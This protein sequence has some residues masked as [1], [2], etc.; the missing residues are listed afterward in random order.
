[1]RDRAAAI[2]DAG[3][4]AWTSEVLGRARADRL[5]QLAADPNAPAFFGR[6]DYDDEDF[7]I[8]RRHIRNQAGDPVVIDWRAPMSTSFYRATTDDPQG[9]RRR[10]R[11]GFAG[12]RLTSYED[13]DL[14]AGVVDPLQSQILLQEIERPRVGPMRDIV[15][16]IQPDQDEIVRADLYQD[17]CVQGAPGTGKTAVGLHRAAYLIYTYPDRLK[18]AKILIVGPNR[19]FLSYIASVLP[20]LGEFDVDQASIEEITTQVAIRSTDTPAVARLKGD[21]RMAELIRRALYRQIAKPTDSVLV[22]LAGKK[23]RVSDRH[24][25]RYVDDLRRSEVA[26]LAGRERLGLA[27]AEDAR[28]QREEGGGSPTDA[29]LRRAARSR[30][31]QSACD[32][33]WPLTKPDVLVHGLL[34]DRATLTGAARGLLTDEEISL[35]LWDKPPA[36]PKRVKWSFGDA[37]LV[38]EAAGLLERV[39]SYGHVVLDEAQDLSPMQCRS[40]ARRSTTGSLTILGDIA[41]GTSDWATKT[42]QETLTHLGRPDARVEPLTLG[43]RVP[44]EIIDFANKLLPRIAPELPLSAS[45]RPGRGSLKI[46]R[47]DSDALDVE[48]AAIAGKLSN[49]EGTTGVICADASVDDVLKTLTTHGVS[50]RRLGSDDPAH[51][52]DTHLE[53]VAATLVKGLEFDHVL[54]V[55][56]AAI[57]DA[58]DRGL[59]R[60]YVCLTRAVSTLHI[61][62]T[63]PIPV[64]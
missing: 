6:T 10:R 41:Q 15:A 12:A 60:L 44:G 11:F 25:R 7:H 1:M 42:W 58:E 59:N 28:R 61:V 3:A 5:Q 18:Q 33:V 2:G 48:I 47:V 49:L 56:P 4:D 43:Y 30:E 31:V 36:N 21:G 63:R 26:Y 9:V 20:A 54:L 50:A 40:I 45:V 13:E 27:I 46:H 34:S 17:I 38:D 16:T 52:S 64:P 24:V 32:E 14:T 29:E 51:A 19:S 57:V 55:E 8:G 23:Y 37:V 62:H 22:P 53:I 35:L 39:R